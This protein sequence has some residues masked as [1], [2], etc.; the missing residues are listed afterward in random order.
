MEK[1]C[2]LSIDRLK[3]TYNAGS[4]E[5]ANV[6]AV[7]GV[8]LKLYENEDVGIMGESGCG[9]STLAMQILRLLDEK[10]SSE[11]SILFGSKDI[12]RLSNRQMNTIR[13]DKI[14]ISFQNAL[15]VLNP[16]M[17]VGKQIAEAVKWH[18]SLSGSEINKRVMDLLDMVRLERQWGEAYPHE[19]SGGMRQK[20]IL[21]MALACDPEIL[22][23]DEPTTAL[24]VENKKNIIDLIVS[25]KKEKG[26]SLITISHDVEVISRL[27]RRL[28]VMYGG[29][30]VES[31]P[32][33][34]VLEEPFH[35]YTR[36]FL[37]SSPVFF[38]YKDL[39]GIRSRLEEKDTELGGDACPFAARCPQSTPDCRPAPKMT[40]A[41]PG[42]FVACH[43]GGVETLMCVQD[44][45]KTY[46]TH[47]RTVLAVNGVNI[48]IRSGE[49]IALIGKSGSGKSTLAQMMVALTSPETGEVSFCGK[50]VC[51]N[52]VTR[53]QQGV[54]IVMQ[55]PISATNGHMRI[56]DAVSEPLTIN[57]IGSA[58]ENKAKVIRLLEMVQLPSDEEF[59]SRRCS[60]L[61]GGQRQR[62]SIA[63]ALTM[64]PRV[65]IADEITSMLDPSTQANLMRELKDIQNRFG[66]TLVFI[67]H[68]LYMA[69]KVAD[70]VFVMH[71]GEIV[72][73]GMASRIFDFPDSAVT[74]KLFDEFKCGNLLHN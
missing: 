41:T 48:K 3:I 55:D 19:L 22:I 68:D 23:L 38:Q 44:I 24:D 7:R 31:G 10:A 27:S 62:L 63:R 17:T 49:V 46:K 15:E 12:C 65:L 16:I 73:E 71:E 52:W 36:G 25:L 58:E 70:R 45:Q 61:S 72:E 74:Q 37:N 39:W 9:K 5:K 56:I 32:T 67:T 29:Y 33:H 14:A 8:N 18:G 21:A 20:V 64:N 51:G 69:R 26:F 35:T 6:H 1:K 42:R 30:F 43:K 13:W 60:G 47:K 28:Y 34:S 2:L 54:Q 59:L 66:F 50:T 40:E 53:M 11:G 57:S 4:S